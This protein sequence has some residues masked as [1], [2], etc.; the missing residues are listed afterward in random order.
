LPKV[1]DVFDRHLKGKTSLYDALLT[2]KNP[3]CRL[4]NRIFWNESDSYAGAGEVLSMIP[5]GFGGR[6]LDIPAGTGVFTADKYL[7]LRDA[8]I[9]CVDFSH[10]MLGRFKSRLSG[11]SCGHIKFSHGDVGALEFADGSFDLV[12][13][14]NGFHC[15][16][17]K[18]RALSEIW[19]VLKRGGSL[20]GCSYVKGVFRRTDFFVKL[21]YDGTVF[22]PPYR[23]AEEF[24][25]FLA[26]RF[27]VVRYLLRGSFACFEVRKGSDS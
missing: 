27:S 4:Y 1:N 11:V 2:G 19:R 8:D 14:M 9:H 26:E 3:F 18:E 6:L 25:A 20:I 15:F 12:L 16:P 24:R 17:E 22:L 13:S 10:E 23:S 21:M 7:N 5:D